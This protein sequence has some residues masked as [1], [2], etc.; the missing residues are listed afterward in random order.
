VD[1]LRLRLFCL[2]TYDDNIKSNCEQ[3]GKAQNVHFRALER[4]VSGTE[5]AAERAKKSDERSGAVNGSRKKNERSGAWSGRSRS[6]K[7]AESADKACCPLY[8]L[9]S[10]LC[11]LQFTSR[12]HFGGNPNEGRRQLR[13]ADSRTCRKADLQQ[14]WS[15]CFEAAGRCCGTAFQLFLGKRT[16]ATNSLSGV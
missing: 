6:G 2:G 3:H 16:S 13:S 9:Y 11:S 14:F 5:N 8:N 4:S 10:A 15:R 7:W 12:L 1:H